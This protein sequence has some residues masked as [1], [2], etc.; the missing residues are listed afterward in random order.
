MST[1]FDVRALSTKFRIELDDSLST[2][3]QESIKAHWV[4]LAHDSAG[5]PDQ[6]IRF[7]VND[8]SDP[9]DGPPRDP[10]ELA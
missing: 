5:E 7:G 4:D 6:V 2:A 10:R 9:L 8:H 1:A 3:D